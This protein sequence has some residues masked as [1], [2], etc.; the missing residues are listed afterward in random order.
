MSWTNLSL[1]IHDDDIQR[2]VARV[3][4]ARPVNLSSKLYY[5]D[6]QPWRYSPWRWQPPCSSSRDKARKPQLVSLARVRGARPVNLSSW[7]RAPSRGDSGPSALEFAGEAPVN[8]S[9]A[10]RARPLAPSRVELAEV[11]QIP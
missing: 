5:G 10:G 3:R 6:T 9:F 7:G 8:L 11:L 2:L 4:G 1:F